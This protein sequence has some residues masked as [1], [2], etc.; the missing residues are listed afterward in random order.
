MTIPTTTSVTRYTAG[1]SDSTY[2]YSFKIQDDDDIEVIVTDTAGTNTTL[3]KTTH[4]TVSGVGASSGSITLLGAYSPLTVDYKLTLRLRPA[5]NNQSAFR[6]TGRL[7]LSTLE[8]AM[9]RM[10]QRI[11]RIQDEVDR[12]L[13]IPASEE[14]VSTKTVFP[15]ATS[16]AGGAVGWDASG[17]L[18]VSSS[19]A[20]SSTPSVTTVTVSG[21]STLSSVTASGTVTLS[22]LTA[23]QLVMTNGSKALASVAAGTTIAEA[24]TWS[25]V[26]TLSGGLDITSAA[27]QGV[28]VYNTADQ[29]T[30]YER[31]VYRF[32]SNVG[33][34]GFEKGGSGTDRACSIIHGSFNCVTLHPTYTGLATTATGTNTVSTGKVAISNS[35]SMTATSGTHKTVSIGENYVPS[36]SSTARA[37]ALELGNTVN[38]ASGGAGTVI[39]LAVET[40]AT[41]L[42]SGRNAAISLNSGACTLGGIQLYGVGG[43]VETNYELATINFTGNALKLS[44]TKGGSGTLRPFVFSPG[45]GAVHVRDGNNVQ[46][47]YIYHSYTDDSNYSRLK[48][49]ASS[50]E[51]KTEKAGSGVVQAMEIGVGGA[52]NIDIYQNGGNRWRFNNSDGAFTP[53]GTSYPIGTSGQPVGTL[54]MNIMGK[55]ITFADAAHI[56]LNT[57]T[58]TKIG[59]GT[60]QKIG[61]WDATPVIQP[62]HIADPAGGAT[63]DAE[64]RAA[65]ASIN[66][67]LAATGLTAAS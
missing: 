51:I 64:A 1:G 33:T 58:G 63:V 25:G 48:I 34:M 24:L 49:G 6:D 46:T 54:Y 3:T 7:A 32:S 22:A 65:I 37:T 30:N 16:R 57:G 36:G 18:S 23:S 12:C 4:Y 52:V 50:G 19:F 20:G 40:T 45:D 27:T 5:L 9:D 38:Y 61:F 66:A 11:I 47:V 28:E 62:V 17:L 39:A 15:V 55:S 21:L 2:N 8:D 29:A 35:S 31:L 59:T 44:T 14:G 10:S 56:T 41:A 67:M 13:K 26:Q 60:G 42:P 43:P 53:V